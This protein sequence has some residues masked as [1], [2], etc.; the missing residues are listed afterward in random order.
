M[1]AATGALFLPLFLGAVYGLSLI[2]PP[3]TADVAARTEREPM[4]KTQRR[5]FVRRY[6]PALVVLV[7]VYLLLTSYRDF[8]DNYAAEI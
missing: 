3:S 7:I 2:P 5:A 8:R 4:T 1:P 6:W